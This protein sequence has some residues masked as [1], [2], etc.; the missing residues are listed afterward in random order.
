MTVKSEVYDGIAVVAVEGELSDEVAALTREAVCEFVD[1]RRL[2]DVVID[3]TACTEVA[4]SGLEALLWAKS[5][6][7]QCYG[8]FK[9]AGG[10][11]FVLK[12]LEMT[13]LRH[14]FECCDSVE[15]ALK[16]MRV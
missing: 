8:R 14:R 15:S 11:E 3:L 4:S 16:L 5:R 13:R 2:A 6:C 12:I 9:L 1:H 7:E 10:G